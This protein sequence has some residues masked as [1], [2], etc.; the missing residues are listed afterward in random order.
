MLFGFHI[1][2]PSVSRADDSS[3]KSLR[4]I[5]YLRINKKKSGDEKRSKRTESAEVPA[6]QPP[7]PEAPESCVGV[8]V[9]LGL[10]VTVGAGDTDGDGAVVGDGVAVG[11]ARTEYV[12]DFV[13]ETPLV[14][15]KTVT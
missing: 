14:P 2:R 12:I 13:S 15:V 6:E 8:T 11:T 4:D 1:C 10:N 7:P 9:T 5:S 3:Q